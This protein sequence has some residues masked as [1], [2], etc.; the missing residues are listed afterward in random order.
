[1]YRREKHDKCSSGSWSPVFVLY[2]IVIMLLYVLW[3]VSHNDTK[4]YYALCSQVC[5]AYVMLCWSW[6]YK[7]PLTTYVLLITTR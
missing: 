5:Y 6:Y 2:D 3:C 4:T 1:M 7:E